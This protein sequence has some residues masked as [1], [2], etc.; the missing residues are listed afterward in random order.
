MKRFF[1]TSLV[2]LFLSVTTLA[3]DEQKC[4]NVIK[5]IDYVYDENLIV[6][7]I[8][9]FWHSGVYDN[10][11]YNNVITLNKRLLQLDPTD[12]ETLTN[13][14]WL[15]YS[16]W[17]TWKKD[18]VVMP[19]GEGKIDEA[20]FLI[21][22]YEKYNARNYL[23][24]LNVALQM[25]ALFKYH[26]NDLIPFSINYYKKVVSLVPRTS[27]AE[28]VKSRLRSELNLGHWYSF[29]NVDIANAL[30]WYKE[31]LIT[32]PA[33]RVAQRR[34]KEIQEQGLNL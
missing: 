8:D 25:D 6:T 14:L 10:F 9:F 20:F 15:L 11:S 17:V 33:N 21:D 2:S 28:A 18:P 4:L 3:Q 26:R 23:F 7:C 13:T 29:K 5:K 32:D 22:K 16:K 27:S 31:A 12:I 30:V 1:L 24:Y 34:I 19:D